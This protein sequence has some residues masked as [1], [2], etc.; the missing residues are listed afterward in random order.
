LGRTRAA[1]SRK[2]AG[3]DRLLP[4]RLAIFVR[5]HVETGRK[6]FYVSANFTL[7]FK[8]MT[9]EESAPLLSWLYQHAVRPEFTCRFR[10]R[11]NSIAFWD[12]RCV[13]HNAI[14][15]YQGWRGVMYRV[16][17]ERE[18]PPIWPS[19]VSCPAWPGRRPMWIRPRGWTAAGI[20]LAD[21]ALALLT[22]ASQRR[23]L[24]ITAAQHDRDCCQARE[25]QE[26]SF[27][28]LGY[29]IVER[30]PASQRSDREQGQGGACCG[31]LTLTVLHAHVRRKPAH[32][33]TEGL[34]PGAAKT[35][36]AGTSRSRQRSR[37]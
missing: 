17:I 9:E 7:R 25:R 19:P 18:R 6:C 31:P 21:A 4:A 22:G 26:P 11:A 5:T 2:T 30:P 14:N 29:W 20:G 13:Q 32:V 33:P 8:D 35:C 10:W 16:T 24:G 15:D 1:S 37:K 28:R 27:S 36:D 23:P 34:P 12:N 3:F